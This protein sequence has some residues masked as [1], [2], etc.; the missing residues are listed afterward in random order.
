MNLRGAIRNWLE[1]TRMS[2][3]VKIG[4]VFILLSLVFGTLLIANAYLTRQLIGASA[5]I[6]Y[7]G[8]QRM[9]VYRLAHLMRVLAPQGTTQ[10]DRNMLAREMDELERVLAGLE[11]GDAKLGLVG[12]TDPE[13]R[14]RIERLRNGWTASIRPAL[15]AAM[16]APPGAMSPSL[17]KYL[18]AAPDFAKALSEVV[19]LIERRLE[20]RVD[21]LYV[22]QYVFL[23]VA[24]G[25][26]AAGIYGLHRFVRAPLEKLTEGVRQISEGRLQFSIPIRSQDELGQLARAFEMM[27]GSIHTHIEHLEAMHATGREFSLLGTGGLEHVL[28]RTTDTAAALVKADL[29]VLMV[30]HPVIDCWIVEAASGSAHTSMHKQLVLLEQTPFACQAFDTKQPVVAS[31]VDEYF[32][33]PLLFRDTFGAKSYLIVPLLGAHEAIGVLVMLRM[34]RSRTFT[35]REIRLALQSAAY[36]AIALENA[37]LFEAAESEVYDL[38]ERVQAVERQVAELTHEVK[39]PAGRVAEFA[40]WI[41]RDYGDR[42]DERA[43][44]Y[45]TWIKKEGQDL[46]QLAGR[47]LDLARLIQEPTPLERVDAGQVVREM[48]DPRS[49]EFA[50]KGIR[51]AVTPDLPHLAC[52]R[53]HLK[54]V[55]ENLIS[56]AV[57][58]MGGQPA[59]RI[60]IGAQRN[61]GGLQLYVRDN[62]VGMDPEMMDRIFLP[63]QRLGDV[64]AAGAG[65]GLSIVKTIVEHYGGAVT[66]ES[67]PGKG[68]TFYVRLPVLEEKWPGPLSS[69][70]QSTRDSE[71][72]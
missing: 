18:A 9:R 69:E 40:A 2:I 67:S 41:E 52:R 25:L 39:A 44:R 22:L 6:N 7:A 45:L 36:A 5:A 56:N 23:I 14:G 68:S 58:Y 11:N 13:I 1:E 51:I 46:A 29:A 33:K 37:R 21:Y 34:T 3:T 49:E 31:D 48:L 24:C 15:E 50:A 53:V 38:R 12:E 19:G 66:V 47:T 32:D 61:E 55:M 27:A 20:A 72:S 42:L 57:K 35:E 10:E 30:R 26:A 65:I 43:R 62:G 54:Q 16:V 4:S 59:P 71:S 70:H 17:S 28:K 60:E 64:E 63:F 8:T